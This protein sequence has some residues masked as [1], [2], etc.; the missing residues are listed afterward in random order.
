MMTDMQK[1]FT[2]RIEILSDKITEQV[3]I[4]DVAVNAVQRR[5]G[6]VPRDIWNMYKNYMSWLNLNPGMTYESAAIHTSFRVLDTLVRER[7]DY[8]ERRTLSS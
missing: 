3:H 5:N 8:H 7:R 6:L 2:V 1:H 4:L